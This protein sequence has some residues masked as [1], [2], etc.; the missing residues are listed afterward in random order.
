MS[1]ALGVLF[2]GF[3]VAWV[4]SVL[5]PGLALE[6]S[7]TGFATDAD[8]RDALGPLTVEGEGLWRLAPD[9][10]K[11]ELPRELV[12][13]LAQERGPEGL[14]ATHVRFGVHAAQATGPSVTVSRETL[15]TRLG[16]LVGT[17]REIEVGEA[18]F[19]DRFLLETPDEAAAR[20][21]L[22]GPLRRFVD[23]LFTRYDLRE[24]EFTPGSVTASVP[25]RELSRGRALNLVGSLGKALAM[26]RGTPF[27]VRVETTKLLAAQKVRCGYCKTDLTGKEPDLVRCERCQGVVHDACWREHGACPVLGCRGRALPAGIRTS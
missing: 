27:R 5:Q 23:E 19:D 13:T 7:G 12:A 10:V 2:A 16:K 3:L 14:D 9:L 26:A 6:R 22:D 1:T 21:A 20:K 8:L 25:L 17:V 11:R 15:A 4:V 18:A 24:L